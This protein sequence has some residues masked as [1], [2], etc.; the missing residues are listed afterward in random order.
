MIYPQQKATNR[1]FRPTLEPKTG[2]KPANDNRPRPKPANDNKPKLPSYVLNT[3]TRRFEAKAI[4]KLGLTTAI[5]LNPYLRAASL[6]YDI[7]EWFNANYGFLGYDMTGWSLCK[8]K[9]PNGR[10]PTLVETRDTGCA[11]PSKLCENKSWYKPYSSNYGKEIQTPPEI[12]S[13]HFWAYKRTSSSNPDR[14]VHELVEHWG[15]NE[16]GPATLPQIRDTKFI[17]LPTPQQLPA[18]RPYPYHL[19]PKRP[20][21]PFYETGPKP[22]LPDPQTPPKPALNFRPRKRRNDTKYLTKSMKVLNAVATFFHALTE[23]IDYMD[24]FV[25]AMGPDKVKEYKNLN[26]TL[27]DQMAFIINNLEHIDTEE[28]KQGLRKNEVEDFAIGNTMQLLRN[29]LKHLE[30]D[31]IYYALTNLQGLT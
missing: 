9:C 29:G 22:Q 8:P 4:A 6:G 15:R 23:I 5:K 30:G 28:L 19:I 3:P 24:V 12:N 10:S 17:P 27:V 7:Y 18:P 31:K 2:W 16:A 20:Q 21:S 13:I 14:D 25:E 11:G 1:D 26:G